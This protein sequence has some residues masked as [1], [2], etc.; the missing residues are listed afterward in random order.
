VRSEKRK[1]EKTGSDPSDMVTHA[2]V[3]TAL[4]RRAVG[5]APGPVWTSPILSA[6]PPDKV[7]I[8]ARRCR[9][10]TG[11]A[12]RIWLRFAVAG[13]TAF[14]D[15]FSVAPRHALKDTRFLSA[16]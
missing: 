3:W 9:S 8:L 7:F 1:A 15:A 4:T 5:L 6:M 14:L 2:P 10:S 13:T 11:S 12:L 16:G